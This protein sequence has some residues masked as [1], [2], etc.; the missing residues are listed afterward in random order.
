MNGLAVSVDGLGK[1]YRIGGPA[2]AYDT[3]RDNIA[4]AWKSV[5]STLGKATQVQEV[6]ALKDVSFDLVHGEVLGI[7]GRNGAGKSTLLKILSH[8]VEP[9]EGQARV[10]GRV[11]SLLEVGTGFHPEL[12]GRE[13]IFLNGAV[14]GMTRA[15]IKHRFDDIVEFAGIGQYLDT[16]VKFYSSGMH[17]RLA[18]AVGAHL[19]PEVLV[20]D[21]A[22]AVGDAEFQARCLR[23]MRDAGREGRTVL[24]VSH[25]LA[26]VEGLCDRAIV[27]ESGSIVYDGATHEAIARYLGQGV[28]TTGGIDV[29]SAMRS[30]DGMT[31]VLTYIETTDDG[32][33]QVSSVRCGGA[34]TVRMRYR[35]SE[36]LESP[37]FGIVFKRADGLVVS[38]LNSQ[39]MSRERMQ[40]GRH[41]EVVCRIGSLPLLPGD[42]TLSFGVAVGVETVDLVDDVMTITVTPADYY[43]TGR[44]PQQG[45]VLLDGN[46]TSAGDA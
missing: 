11:G 14:L 12:S 1:R 35:H 22:L 13:N 46:W 15:D 29:A 26:A 31:P 27:L 24:F 28:S 33:N 34:L 21:E 38:H 4:G 40:S 18:F 7:I 16:P 6:W 5:R 30:A 9:T 19:D 20:I 41:G 3:L 2:P 43:G 39:T 44:V 8:V 37:I 42:Y 36:R 32:G 10:R 25:N 23:K 45:I 17:M